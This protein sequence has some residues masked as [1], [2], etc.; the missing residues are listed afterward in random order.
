MVLI[1]CPC[2]PSWDNPK[3]WIFWACSGIFCSKDWRGRGSFYDLETITVVD[4]P[5]R[6]AAGVGDS[7]ARHDGDWGRGW[8]HCL[9]L[10]HITSDST[11]HSLS[12][13]SII[14]SSGVFHRWLCSRMMS[15]IGS[16]DIIDNGRQRKYLVYMKILCNVIVPSDAARAPLSQ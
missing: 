8:G 11:W 2:D 4:W 9:G 16:D 13:M 1:V 7:V 14:N 15:V 6:L 5:D 12:L 10:G 3:I